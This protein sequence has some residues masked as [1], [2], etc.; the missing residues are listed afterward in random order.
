MVDLQK[1]A[2]EEQEALENTKVLLIVIQQVHLTVILV[3]QQLQ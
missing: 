1:V 2:E 3:E